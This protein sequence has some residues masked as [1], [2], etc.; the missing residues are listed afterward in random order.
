MFSLCPIT[1]MCFKYTFPITIFNIN[2]MCFCK[3]TQSV[4][5]EYCCVPRPKIVFIFG[6]YKDRVLRQ[7]Q[8]KVVCIMR[9]R[10]NL[11]YLCSHLQDRVYTVIMTGGKRMNV[12][13]HPGPHD[14]KEMVHTADWNKFI[15]IFGDQVGNTVNPQINMTQM[16]WLWLSYRTKITFYSAPS[17]VLAKAL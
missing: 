5:E 16:S 9:M 2:N 7:K 13:M 12:R 4:L 10:K 6:L 17:S 3:S 14:K 8:E 11:S 1:P 15:S